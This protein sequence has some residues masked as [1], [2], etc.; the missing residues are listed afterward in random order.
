[1]AKNEH[2][3]RHNEGKPQLSYILDFPKTMEAVS[4]VL[5]SGAEKYEKNNW[6][7]GG[8]LTSSEDSLLRHILAFHNCQD[9][10]IESGI[11]H[12]AHVICN[13]AFMLENYDRHGKDIDNRD[14]KNEAQR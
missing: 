13:A 14:W 5:E 6:K 8:T 2:M 12:L 3:M 9:N 4:R 1:M 10:D 7:L 11:S